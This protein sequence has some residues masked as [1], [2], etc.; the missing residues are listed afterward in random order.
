[1]ANRH[2]DQEID[3]VFNGKAGV[4]A[5]HFNAQCAAQ[6]GQ[7]RTQSKSQAEYTVNI[8]AH[9]TRRALVIDGCAQLSAKTRV[10]HQPL[11]QP[12]NNQTDTNQEQAVN[13]NIQAWK[14]D[15]TLQEGGQNQG[16]LR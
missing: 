4:Q 9:A 10:H 14:I 11:Q 12:D 5:K 1:A 6:P 16:L 2:H 3:D 13:T 8:N 7:R 15:L